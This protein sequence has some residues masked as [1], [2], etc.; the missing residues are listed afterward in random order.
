LA[1][2]PPFPLPF[3]FFAS[4]SLL[5][6]AILFKIYALGLNSFFPDYHK[7]RFASGQNIAG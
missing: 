4:M 3:T 5:L 7:S 2:F 6:S 1:V